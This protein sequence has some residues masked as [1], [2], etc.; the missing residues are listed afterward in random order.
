MERSRDQKRGQ[1]LFVADGCASIQLFT[2]TS[3]VFLSG[4][5]YLVGAS[6]AVI[7]IIVTIPVL[8]NVVQ[9][10]SSIIYEN[11][12]KSKRFIVGN[13]IIQRICMISILFVPLLEVRNTVKI[14]IIVL[15]YSVAHFCGAL[16]NTG[17]SNWMISIV[18]ENFL[19]RFL[20][21]RDALTLIASMVGG[22]AFSKILDAYKV[23]NAELI[24]FMV[25]GLLVI[26]FG[27]ID[28]TCLSLI[29]E[30]VSKEKKEKIRLRDVVLIP[31][32]DKRYQKIL[33]FFGAWSIFTNFAAP[34][35]SVY[36]LKNLELSYFYITAVG[37]IA[38]VSRILT[39]VLWGKIADE[40]SWNFVMV[41]SII[42]MGLTY[43]G[44]AAITKENYLYMMPLVQC[45]NGVAS[46]GVNISMFCLPFQMADIKHRVSYVSLC[47]AISGI[48]GFL[49]SMSAAKLIM[50]VNSITIKTVSI[51]NIQLIFILSAIGILVSAFYAKNLRKN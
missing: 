30:P 51:S 27:I 25:I 21:I 18:N 36:M 4:I 32:R 49:T 13:A 43:L 20:G 46:G 7:G 39:A 41:V 10:F 31:L 42:M 26:F 35:F 37:M 44:W 23:Q 22:L 45:I 11:R 48:I 40:K 34:F 12:N 19:G 14:M 5:L 38:S 29:K 8:M 3:G 28:L 17:A 24:G 9:V 6:T 33:I 50:N 1:I 16:I 15:L 2:V 47:S